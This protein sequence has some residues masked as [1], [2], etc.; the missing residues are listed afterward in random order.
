MHNIKDIRDHPEEFDAYLKK[1]GV[2]PYAQKILELDAALRQVIER[3]QTLQQERNDVA[4]KMA[5]AKKEGQD[6]APL[7]ADGARIKKALPDLE[8]AERS[9]KDA[10]HHMLATLPN[11][12]ADDTPPGETEAQNKVVEIVGEKTEFLFSPKEHF[13][14]GEQKGLMDFDRAAKLSGSR[15]S[16]LKGEFAELERALAQFMID[17]H[18][19][20][21]GYELVSP[22]LLVRDD[23]M[24]GTGQL[25]KFSEDAF[26]TI[27]GHWL[28]PT[29]EVPLTCMVADSVVEEEKLPLRYTAH[30]AC[31]RSEAGSAGRDTRGMLRQHQ[32]Y[33]VELVSLVTAEQAEA[34]FNYMVSAARRVLDGLKLPYR[35]VQL[36]SG[37]IGFSAKKTYDLEVWL[38]GQNAYREISSCSYC[39]DFQA[40]RMNGRFKTKDGKKPQFLHTLNGSGVAVG[41]ALIAVLENYQNEDGSVKVPDVLVPYMGGKKEVNK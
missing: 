15:F 23:A 11:T 21:F 25:P 17:T 2:A 5:I 12:V 18:T 41:R 27:K 1:R 28:I 9:A 14:I 26:Q 32:F 10:L 33:K 38:P 13:E 7:V 29:A 40:R 37:D 24:F 36:C 19:K 31:F 16:I 3:L 20:E 30:T 39:G 22:P 8:D 35:V 34:E 6:M 4:S